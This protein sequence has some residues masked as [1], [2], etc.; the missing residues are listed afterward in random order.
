MDTLNSTLEK[1]IDK[2]S[3][4]N[5]LIRLIY[6]QYTDQ[7]NYLVIVTDRHSLE[8]YIIKRQ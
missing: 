2:Q 3:N 6:F 5:N 1:K 7:S 4:T 8:I